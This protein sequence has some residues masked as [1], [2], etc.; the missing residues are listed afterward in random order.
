M[1]VDRYRHNYEGFYEQKLMPNVYKEGEN[2]HNSKCSHK[3]CE[4]SIISSLS[5]LVMSFEEEIQSSK[6]LVDITGG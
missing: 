4:N 3:H 2:D 5:L 1:D 6:D